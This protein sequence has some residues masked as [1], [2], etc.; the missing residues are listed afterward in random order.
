MD[1]AIWLLRFH[2][3]ELCAGAIWLQFKAYLGKLISLPL[4]REHSAISA[5][6]V[7]QLLAGRFG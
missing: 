6:T 1:W 7:T 4:A 2:I 3:D 5:N